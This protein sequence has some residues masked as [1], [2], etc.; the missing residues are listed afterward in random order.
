MIGLSLS[1]CVKDI[2]SGKVA[3]AEVTKII[4]NTAAATESDWEYLCARYRRIYWCRFDE[5]AVT[6]LIQRLRAQ[7]K[8][9]QPRL[10]NPEYHH[11]IH[12]GIWIE[13]WVV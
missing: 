11:S 3:E 5:A 1:F 12:A 7:D 4:T 9:E 8:I 6:E 10:L 2:M 13:H